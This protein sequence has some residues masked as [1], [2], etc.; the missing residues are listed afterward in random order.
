MLRARVRDVLG[1]YRFGEASRKYSQR[2]NVC[3][4]CV[5]YAWHFPTLHVQVRVCFRVTDSVQQTHHLL[6]M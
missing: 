6:Y 3:L 2:R 5:V 4:R 1:G